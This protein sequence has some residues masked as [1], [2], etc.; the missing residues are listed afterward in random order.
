MIILIALFTASVFSLNGLGEDMSV[1]RSPFTN[2]GKSTIISIR[3][4][5]EFTI[6]YQGSDFCGIF[7]THPFQFSL[8]APVGKGFAIGFGNLERFDQSFD[9]YFQEDALDI[10]LDGDGGVDELYGCVAKVF[11]AGE[12]A[13][14]GSYLFGNAAEIWQYTM[15]GYQ[16][17]DTFEYSYEG[18]ILTIGLR[19]MFLS[20]SFELGDMTVETSSTDTSITLPSR[21]SLGLGHTIFG[22]RADLVFERSF[23]P[24]GDDYQDCNRLKLGFFKKRTGISYHFNP[25][26]MRGITEHGIT[27]DYHLPLMRG[28]GT[29]ALQLECL[30]RHKDDL[31]E[32]SISPGI[33]L[34]IRELFARRRK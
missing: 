31:Y 24:E 4:K 10:Y 12:I 15:G 22:G 25:W 33:R 16:L 27:F 23:W 8:T 19:V 3:M 30:L 13:L 6:L 21:L 2:I 7:W 20:A 9:I 26:Y 18:K 5:P 11:P 17:I 1:F 29:V 28:A 14:R 32:W 34:T